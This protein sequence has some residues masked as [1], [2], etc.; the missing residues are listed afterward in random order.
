MIALLSI[1]ILITINLFRMTH[2]MKLC[3]LLLLQF[4]AFVA[5]KFLSFSVCHGIR[6]L[7]FLTDVS[8]SNYFCSVMETS[9]EVFMILVHIDLI[10]NENSNLAWHV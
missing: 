1:V 6:N 5:G 10:Y 3:L 8:Y 4:T 7:I 9:C 2:K